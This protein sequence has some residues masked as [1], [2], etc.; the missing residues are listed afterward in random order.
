M[1]LFRNGDC[2]LVARDAPA[3]VEALAR[4]KLITVL[5]PYKN[6]CM[7]EADHG[8]APL[9]TVPVSPRLGMSQDVQVS[10]VAVHVT[11]AACVVNGDH[12]SAIG[13]REEKLA[14]VCPIS[15]A[16]IKCTLDIAINVLW[17]RA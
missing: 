5:R 2:H 11:T 17:I 14:A 7:P 10:G 15:G 4:V 16:R 12:A 3:A 13:K 8:T 9:A 6:G 1:R